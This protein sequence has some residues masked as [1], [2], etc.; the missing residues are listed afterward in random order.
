LHSSTAPTPSPLAPPTAVR[1]YSQ[2]LARH[3]DNGNLQPEILSPW[4]DKVLSLADFQ[5]FTDWQALK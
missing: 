1:R 4:L 3:L 5:N 2:F